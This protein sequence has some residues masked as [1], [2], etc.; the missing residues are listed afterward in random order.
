MSTAF[1]FVLGIQGGGH[2]DSG[3]MYV[4][5]NYFY[6]SNVWERL[7]SSYYIQHT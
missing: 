6:A 7:N 5:M 2:L 3:N 4:E 1:I